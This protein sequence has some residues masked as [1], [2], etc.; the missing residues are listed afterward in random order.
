M[1]TIHLAIQ[2][3]DQTEFFKLIQFK[4]IFLKNLKLIK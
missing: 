4:I 2:A 3:S 1:N